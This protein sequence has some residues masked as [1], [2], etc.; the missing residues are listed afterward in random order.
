MLRFCTLTRGALEANLVQLLALSA[1]VSP[2]K[3]G[4]FRA[5]L[6]EKWR[7]SF[8]AVDEVLMGYAVL[9]QR[10]ANW[11]HLH[12]FMVGPAVRGQ[13]VGAKMLDEVKARCAADQAKLTLKVSA[14]D[15]AAQRFYH[16]EGLTPG[17]GER[18]YLWMHWVDQSRR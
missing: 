7:L 14:A 17:E 3:E 18:G 11:V 1:D 8:Y 4:H 15:E 12:Q 16:R 5:E 13:G 10:G 6:P 2:W 9:S